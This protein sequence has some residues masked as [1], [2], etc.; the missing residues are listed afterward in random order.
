MPM[1]ERTEDGITAYVTEEEALNEGRAAMLDRVTFREHVRKISQESGAYDITY[2]DDRHVVLIPVDTVPGSTGEP[3]SAAVEGDEDGDP[4]CEG[5]NGEDDDLLRG[6][7]IGET[8]YCDGSCRPQRPRYPFTV[9]IGY[10]PAYFND[11]GAA[12]RCAALYGSTVTVN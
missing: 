2:K 9:M 10:T 3:A 4:V 11:R 7:G 8:T 6:V 1:Y 12:D 5:H